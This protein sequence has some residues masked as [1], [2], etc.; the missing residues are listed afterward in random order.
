MGSILPMNF[1]CNCNTNVP[2]DFYFSDTRPWNELTKKADVW[3]K[4]KLEIPYLENWCRTKSSLFRK[5]HTPINRR[6]YSRSKYDSESEVAVKKISFNKLGRKKLGM[7]V[8][9]F[10]WSERDISYGVTSRRRR[11]RHRGSRKPTVTFSF[12]RRNWILRGQR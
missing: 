4:T 6:I 7:W 11:L 1:V 2:Y 3:K 12:N 5:L 9:I 8:G 10:T